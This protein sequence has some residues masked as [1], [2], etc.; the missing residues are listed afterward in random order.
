MVRVRYRGDRS[1]IFIAIDHDELELT[2]LMTLL[3]V[4]TSFYDD[5]F[6]LMAA[7]VV[8]SF[9]VVNDDGFS[10]VDDICNDL[11]LTSILA[12]NFCDLLALF[13]VLVPVRCSLQV[14]RITHYGLLDRQ[15]SARRGFE[16]NSNVLVGKLSGTARHVDGIGTNDWCTL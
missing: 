3:T 15:Q 7:L 9:D 1:C 8:C 2:L 5:R 10:F 6:A 11:T 4:Q 14:A 13:S 12:C 16:R